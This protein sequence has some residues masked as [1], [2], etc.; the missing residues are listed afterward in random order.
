MN[1]EE[2]KDVKSKVLVKK[3]DFIELKFTGYSNGQIFD[4]NIPSDLKEIAPKAEPQEMI[5]A[6]GE[7]MVVKGLDEALE[8]KKIGERYEIDVPSREAFGPRRRDLVRIISLKNFTDQ[9]INPQPGMVLALDNHLVKILTVSGA[10]ITVDFNN[11][12]AGRDLEYRFEIVKI[13]TDDEKKA[14]ALFEILFK[15]VPEFE[16]KDKIIVKGPKILEKVVETYSEKFKK[17]IGKGIGFELKE[18]KA[19]E[20]S[21]TEN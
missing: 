12:L 20:K 1:N 9:E 18:E 21:K 14:K 17:L 2:K 16:V 3:G 6:I 5:V 10:R 15:F 13:V 7:G 19:E 4:S 11:P 8:G